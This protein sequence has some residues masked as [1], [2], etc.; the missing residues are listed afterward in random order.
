MRTSNP[1]ARS[2][3]GKLTFRLRAC[4]VQQDTG[5]RLGPLDCPR[6][7]RLCIAI[8]AFHNCKACIA[9]RACCLRA[10]R[11]QRHIPSGCPSH[12]RVHAVRTRSENCLHAFERDFRSID[13]LNFDQWRYQRC[14]TARAQ[15]FCRFFGILFRPRD[16]NAHDLI[17][18]PARN[19]WPQFKSQ[20]ASRIFRFVHCVRAERSVEFCR[21]DIASVGRKHFAAK[22]QSAIRIVASPPIGVRQEPSRADWNARSQA[23]AV[24]VALSFSGPTTDKVRASFLRISIPDRALTPVPATIRPVTAVT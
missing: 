22:N 7:Q 20:F 9:R 12:Q 18:E 4:R 3:F 21:N 11:K 13:K 23:S 5:I 24:A 14:V 6:D 16:E 2:D 10:D 15:K 8:R 1:A 17:F 19:A